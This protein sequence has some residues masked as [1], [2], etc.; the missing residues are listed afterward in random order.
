MAVN[1]A[2]MPLTERLRE[3]LT[4]S[5]KNFGPEV[6]RAIDELLSPTNLAILAGTLM[7]WAGSH[8]FG[9]GEVV[10]VIL[11]VVGAFVIGWSIGDVVKD[12]YTFTERTMNANSEADL[13]AAAK[14]LSHAIVLAGITVVMALLLRKSAKQVETARG[15]TIVAAMRPREPGL[16]EVGPDPFAGKIWSRPGIT[17]DPTLPPGAGTTSPFGEVRLSPHGT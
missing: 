15:P 9:V 5:K 10:D 14:A 1:V 3:V 6:G 13:E 7:L 2:T 16:I 11:L 4:R 17:M 8:L 12:L